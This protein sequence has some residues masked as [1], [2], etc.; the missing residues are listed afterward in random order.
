MAS[1]KIRIKRKGGPGSGNWNHKGRPGMV[2]GSVSG[3]GSSVVHNVTELTRSDF[4]R[5]VPEDI[6]RTAFYIGTI[7]DY[8]SKQVAKNWDISRDDLIDLM[9][10]DGWGKRP[11]LMEEVNGRSTQ[12]NKE[13]Y[14]YSKIRSWGGS[15]GGTVV[16]V[17][18][19]HLNAK[20]HTGSEQIDLGTGTTKFFQ[21]HLSMKKSI[22]S[23]A[24]AMYKTTQDWFKKRG[25][26]HLKLYRGG[27]ADDQSKPYTSWST[28]PQEIRRGSNRI[29]KQAIVPVWQILSIPPT[30]FGTLL[31]REAVVLGP[32]TNWEAIE[33]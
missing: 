28:E 26:T 11:E 15:S 19:N 9:R 1:V 12:K 13:E 14:L 32:V 18:V 6:L 10:E 22:E 25:I 17:M 21:D 2:G 33:W 16:D 5:E 30:G 7:P 23:S 3:G 20:L 29:Y 24:D 31:E 8:S 27:Y 4:S